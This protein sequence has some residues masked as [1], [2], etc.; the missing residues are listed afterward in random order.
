ML[1]YTS[2]K[3]VYFMFGEKPMYGHKTVHSD[4]KGRVSLPVF[5][6]A[7]TNDELVIIKDSK[8]VRVVRQDVFDEY[9][10]YLEGMLKGDRPRKN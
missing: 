10:A 4:K 3:G 7:E 9:I 2:Y 1:K 5:T 8:N 6:G